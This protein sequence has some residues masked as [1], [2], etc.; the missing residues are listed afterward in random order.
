MS[1]PGAGAPP[2]GARGPWLVGSDLSSFLYS[3]CCAVAGC[4]W[5]RKIEFFLKKI[6]KTWFA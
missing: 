4:V 2:R 1:T 3:R 5:L 6:V